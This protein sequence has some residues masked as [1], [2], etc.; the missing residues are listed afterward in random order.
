MTNRALLWTGAACDLVHRYATVWCAAWRARERNA[1]RWSAGEAEFLPAALALQRQPI[2]PLPRVAMTTVVLLLLIALLWA[3][4]GKIDIVATAQG[5]VVP[6]GR[7]KIIQSI[8]TAK[9]TAIHVRDGQLIRAGDVLLELDTTGSS[10]DRLRLRDDWAES[11][12]GAARARAL[13]K[14]IDGGAPQRVV[15]ETDVDAPIEALPPAKR[16]EQEQRY[17]DGELADF[18]SKVARLDAEVARNVAERETAGAMERRLQGTLPIART[19]E[20][21]FATLAAKNYVSRHEYLEKQQARI[22]QEGE[23]AAQKSRMGEIDAAILSARRQR[24]ELIASTRRAT[25]ES[26]GNARQKAAELRQEYIK[27]DAH[28]RF[29][30]LRAP[31]DGAVQQLAVHT[32][33]GVVT[34]AQ[35]LMVIVPDDRAVEVEAYLE[36]KDVGF[37]TVGQPAAVKLET[38]LYTRYG[39]LAAEVV[40]VSHDAIEDEKRGLIYAVRLKL[41]EPSM[42]ID[43][44]RVALSPGMAASVEIKTGKRRLIEYFLSPLLTRVDESFHER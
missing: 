35:P 30:T 8:E 33:G 34:A 20:A 26:L 17:L 1:P 39:T 25:L 32:V 22:E 7:T 24:E 41:H 13:L 9:V 15:D 2:S 38:F 43:G 3:V 19:K 44:Q 28:D 31:V 10:A 42:M 16:I 5:K 18:R 40:S 21:D 27:A 6:D 36:N 4:F 11:W 37:V 23:M 14:G 29:M 12:L